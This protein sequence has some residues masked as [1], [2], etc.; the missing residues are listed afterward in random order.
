MTRAAFFAM[1][2]FLENSHRPHSP[3]A[4]QSLQRGV[5]CG[6]PLPSNSSDVSEVPGLDPDACASGAG[7][8]LK[9][10]THRQAKPRLRRQF[11]AALVEASL[12]N[13]HLEPKHRVK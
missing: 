12:E 1:K 11:C 3:L 13:K 9:G 5:R 6:R 10:R 7:C 8:G 4:L 2:L